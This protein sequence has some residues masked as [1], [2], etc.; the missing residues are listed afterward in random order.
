[1]PAPADR[2]YSDSHEWHKADGNVV[3]IGLTRFAVDELTDITFVDLPEVGDEFEAGDAIGEVE[4]V[5]ATSD[6]YTA[7]AG[8]V[9]EINEK[10][11][12]SPELLNDDPFE[13]GW[14][15]KLEVDDTA[16]LEDLMDAGAYN[17]KYPE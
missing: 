17:E 14:L 13:A 11:D 7:I 3:T 5:K 1:M 8:R 15:L 10:L 2:R 6:V 16:P 12:E 9:T 4:S